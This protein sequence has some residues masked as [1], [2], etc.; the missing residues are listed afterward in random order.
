[1]KS[2]GWKKL[3]IILSV[4]A[5]IVI[6]II[7]IVP[8][9]INLNRYNGL[10]TA[11]VQKAVGGKVNLGHL[12][13]GISNGIWLE[14]DGF[15]ITDATAFPGDIRL[16]RIYTKI[17]IPALFTK[18]ILANELLLE[19]SEVKLRIESSTA[20]KAIPAPQEAKTKSETSPPGAPLTEERVTKPEE[21]PEDGTKPAGF[22]LPVKIEIRRLSVKVER[23][24]LNDA[25]TLPGQTQVHVF[26]DV[27]IGATHIVPG[28]EMAFNFALHDTATSGLGKL[29]GQGTFSG[30]TDTF[31]LE[32]PNLNVKAALTALHADAIKPYLK[33]TLLKNQLDGSLSLD[34]NYEGDLIANQRAQ[35]VIDLSRMTYTNPSLFEK[36]L[37]A[38]QKTTLTYQVKLNPHAI[39]IEKLTL[40]LGKLSLDAS[41]DVHNWTTNP[42]ITNARFSSDVSL[43]DLI[44]LVP[45]KKMG[46]SAK[47]VKEMFL[48]GGNLNIADLIL[49][50]IN[51]S[52]LP[53]DPK[54][55][56]P[57]VKLSASFD[58]ITVPSLQSMPKIE[59]I[60]GRVNLENDV[61]TAD[62]IHAVV[63]PLSLPTVSVHATNI[64]GSPKVG[65]IAK[66][67]LKVAA[68]SDAQI[69][70]LLF[71]YGLKSLT[72][73]ADI[74]MKADFDQRRPK[75]WVANGSLMIE[76]VRA[77]THPEAVVMENLRGKVK[78]NLKLLYKRGVIKKYN[79]NFAIDD[80]RIATKG[81][82][83]LRDLDRIKFVVNPDIKALQL[84]TVAPLFGFEKSPISGPLTLSGR[85]RGH[86]GSTKTLLKSLAGKLNADLGPGRLNK[87]GPLGETFAKL[88][89]LVKVQN[90][91]F[92][93]LGK[94]LEDKGVPYHKVTARTSFDKGVMHLKRAKLQSDAMD[95]T[96]RGSIDLVNQK[97]DINAHLK[98]L[99][100]VDKA[101]H[102]IPLI[103]KAAQHITEIQIDIEGS[104]AGPKIHA[105]PIKKTGNT[106][107]DEAKEPGD[108]LKGFGKELK[109]IF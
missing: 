11:E 26:S 75:S 50:D 55:L 49:P 67:P 103:G 70:K 81:S 32:N 68:T 33:N 31:T 46:E 45:W 57:K 97:L 44:P 9:F 69:E 79:F 93:R 16:S 84:N 13:W 35:G 78:L 74:D 1:M 90:L 10:I 22:Q 80:G 102:F 108:I 23:F 60:T 8:K 38:G 92:G 83:D 88:F 42:V 27:D 54:D 58:D 77:E 3:G 95:A 66:G 14:A 104:L 20:G 21:L 91:L 34:V 39:D 18:T 52:K 17:S 43:R 24:E 72:G 73:S 37:P 99:A 71:K 25:L 65:L 98:P 101:F 5:I 109:K 86:T 15:S 19:G 51:L 76:G 12:S 28:E 48:A 107:E 6:L 53:K 100:T 63:G 89:S 30:L 96:S 56:L 94:D 41:A 87:I 82:A 61:L 40:K 85:L 59:A 4:L 47:L 2:R 29:T 7:V 64:S 36:A 106:I 62:I 105:A